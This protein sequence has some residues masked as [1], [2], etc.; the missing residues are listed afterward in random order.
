MAHMSKSQGGS[1]RGEPASPAEPSCSATS[2]G[3][4]GGPSPSTRKQSVRGQ[5][6][7]LVVV[8]GGLAGLVAALQLA[9]TGQ[10]VIVL[11]RSRALGGRARSETADGFSLN[12][13]PHAL[14]LEGA[15]ARA[16]RVLE[17]PVAG[18]AVSNQGAYAFADGRMHMLPTGP[19][20]LLSTGLLSVNE[21]LE[22]ARALASIPGAATR[23]R[24]DRPFSDWLDAQAR[25]PR[26][27]RLLTS[28]ARVATY[29][30]DVSTLSERA[31]LEQLA[32]AFRGGV[33]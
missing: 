18:K 1:V 16:L 26:A 25:A 19:L 4:R 12:L 23:A 24:S 14:Y 2:S 15:L 29:S 8:G 28:I 3:H 20:S 6:H 21:K 13:G 33:A 9:R 17:V 22:L 32:L 30:R 27:N 10:R 11:E 7:P 5:R 31:V